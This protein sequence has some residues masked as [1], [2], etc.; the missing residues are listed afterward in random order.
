[1]SYIDLCLCVCVD[2]EYGYEESN[3]LIAMS[4]PSSSS[5][6]MQLKQALQEVITSQ[7]SGN[8]SLLLDKATWMKYSSLL[9]DDD[10]R[11]L[12]ANIFVIENSSVDTLHLEN[13]GNIVQF[14]DIASSM[15]YLLSS[16]TDKSSSKSYLHRLFVIGSS[17]QLISNCLQET[18]LD[19][20]VIIK[21]NQSMK[22][23]KFLTWFPKE[24]DKKMRS[25][26]V[27]YFEHYSI[28]TFQKI[29]DFEFSCESVTE[30]HPDKV[31]DIISDSIVDAYIAQDPWSKVACEVMAYENMVWLCG[32]SLSNAIVNEE[33][34][35]RNVL[36]E[37]GLDDESKGLDFK[38]A[39]VSVNIHK[40][41]SPSIR[42]L[43]LIPADDQA[44]M[45]GY[46]NNE[47]KDMM[48]LPHYF[49]TKLTLHL[50]Y[51]RRCA[52]NNKTDGLSP[53][54]IK[55]AYMLRPAGKACV[56]AKYEII[57][58]I[59]R[60]ASITVIVLEAQHNPGVDLDELKVLLRENVIMKILPHEL[61]SPQVELF[62]NGDGEYTHGGKFI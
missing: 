37:L 13:S 24:L 20:V 43:K 22:A 4:N 45:Y 44:V 39:S 57:N 18:A 10:K 26:K 42:D 36:E 33:E 15:R 49:A 23:D 14:K 11:K 50:S 28:E 58:K 56:T 59:K 55:L 60:N 48:P 1:M 46:A 52:F 25:S 8:A 32:Y 21:L 51:L 12:F 2:A 53:S 7:L 3:E 27:D 9:L 47:T 40:S 41:P 31:C 16:L 62:V 30:G 61:L 35:V 6:S 19:Q 54:E 29:Q 38:T 17:E 34:I 5:P